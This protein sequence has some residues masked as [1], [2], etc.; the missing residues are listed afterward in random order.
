MCVSIY[1]H[2]DDADDDGG[3]SDHDAIGVFGSLTSKP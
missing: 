3:D 1:T 2:D